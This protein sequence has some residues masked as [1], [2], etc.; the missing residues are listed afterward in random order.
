MKL[1]H[2]NLTVNDVPGA[3]SFF[4]TYFGLESYLQIGKGFAGL[5]DDDG[6]LLNLSHGR[7]VHYPDTFHV[8][9]PQETEEEVN[10]LN[11][12]LKDNG[13]NVESPALSHG[14]YTFYYHTDYGFTVEVF[15]L[16]PGVDATDGVRP[17]FGKR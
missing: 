17:S 3:L 8:G 11:K 12:R 9:F 6:F 7:E 4:E 5:T 2:L 13:F 1:N 15:C 10:R 16:I 14:S